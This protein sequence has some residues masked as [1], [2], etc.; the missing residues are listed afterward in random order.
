VVFFPARAQL[1]V[2]TSALQLTQCR[3]R[4]N[5]ERPAQFPLLHYSWHVKTGQ[6]TL[7]KPRFAGAPW[8]GSTSVVVLGQGDHFSFSQLAED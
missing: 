3:L 6:G 5:V 1:T 8:P 7:E 4:A 2:S